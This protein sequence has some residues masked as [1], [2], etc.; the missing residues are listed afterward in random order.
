MAGWRTKRRQQAAGWKRTGSEGVC[1]EQ[2]LDFGD[3]TRIGRPLRSK[4][5]RPLVIRQV[6]RLFE[7]CE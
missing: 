7:R 5:R 1:H 2:A 4:P 3:E 6:N